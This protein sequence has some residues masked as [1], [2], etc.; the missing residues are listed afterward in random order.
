M[1]EKPESS[2]RGSLIALRVAYY[3][4]VVAAL[5]AVVDHRFA[6]PQLLSVVVGLA[7]MSFGLVLRIAAGRALGKW[8]SLHVEIK[9]GQP[10]V[11]AGIYRFVRHPAYLGML[12]VCLG[13]PIAFRSMWAA[14][15]MALGVWPAAGHRIEVEERVLASHF[16]DEYRA[17]AQRTARLVPWLF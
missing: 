12:M 13:I 3:G 17:Y 2:D 10:L 6:H 7:L 15:V 14:V 1:T 16:G 4:E 9:P 8:W 11:Q 5:F